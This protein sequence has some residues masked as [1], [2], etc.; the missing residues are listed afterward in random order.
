[1]GT[2]VDGFTNCRHLS[3]ARLVLMVTLGEPG[4]PPVYVPG[5]AQYSSARPPVPWPNSCAITVQLDPSVTIWKPPPPQPPNP[6]SFRM[7]TTRS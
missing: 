2:G 7:M 1:M 3:V 5:F 4:S 6:G